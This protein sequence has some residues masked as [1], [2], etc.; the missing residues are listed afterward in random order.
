MN[1]YNTKSGQLLALIQRPQF[2]KCVKTTQSDK[3]CKEFSQSQ[4][5]VIKAYAKTA[6]PARVE[7]PCKLP[8]LKY[9]DYIN[10]F[11]AF[12]NVVPDVL[13]LYHP[14]FRHSY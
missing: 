14:Q 11:Y 6:N 2:E 9:V 1:K 13:S 12:Y 7:K 3:Y 10:H 5:F 4:Q 8:Q